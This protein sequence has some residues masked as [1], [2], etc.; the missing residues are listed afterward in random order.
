VHINAPGA[1]TY[2]NDNA[3]AY[4]NAPGGIVCVGPKFQKKGIHEM[5][6][7]G[8]IA[9]CR[10]LDGVFDYN[11]FENYFEGL[12]VSYADWCTENKKV[13]ELAQLGEQKLMDINSTD[14]DI[15]KGIF[16]LTEA[17]A[18][19][20]QPAKDLLLKKHD[21]AKKQIES[22]DKDLIAQGLSYLMNAA[23]LR[24]PLASFLLD[25]TVRGAKT[26]LYIGSVAD[27]KK[28]WMFLNCASEAGYELATRF[29]NEPYLQS[30][31]TKA[32]SSTSTT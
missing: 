2:L 27:I 28:A 12:F 22:A 7:G 26:T 30:R 29:L 17:A 11:Y 23:A 24:R 25:E 9:Y 6:D 5:V 19:K 18:K 10:H 31:Y 20:Y 8:I 21:E 3:N 15:K 4:I 13:E 14:D 16:Y 32:A 1:K